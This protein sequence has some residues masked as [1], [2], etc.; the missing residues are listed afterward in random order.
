MTLSESIIQVLSE[1]Q[2]SLHHHQRLLK[3]LKALQDKHE[4]VEFFQAFFQPF[5]NVLVIY[6][7]EPVAERVIDFVAKYAASVAPKLSEGVSKYQLCQECR[8]ALYHTK[9][10][11]R[12][13]MFTKF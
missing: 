5:S 2:S 4:V 8:H 12:E 3:T 11:G 9:F 10:K 1:A 7:R 13:I 6:K